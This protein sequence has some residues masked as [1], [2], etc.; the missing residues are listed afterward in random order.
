MDIATIA[1]LIIGIG[2]VAVA[3]LMEGGAISAILQLPA[4][5]LVIFGTIG[6]A[7]VTTSIET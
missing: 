5:I 6:A 4:M 2:A 1:G 7:T 3:F